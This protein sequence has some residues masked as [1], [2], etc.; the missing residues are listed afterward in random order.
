MGQLVLAALLEPVLQAVAPQVPEGYWPAGA[1]G[2][3]NLVAVAMAGLG[4]LGAA[5]ALAATAAVPVRLG[6]QAAWRAVLAAVLT[7]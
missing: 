7:Y 5:V 1:V 2:H 6:Q 4:R 3:S